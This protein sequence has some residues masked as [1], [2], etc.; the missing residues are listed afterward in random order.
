[1]NLNELTAFLAAGVTGAINAPACE[2]LSTLEMIMAQVARDLGINEVYT[3]DIAN[4]FKQLCY[5]PGL[6]VDLQDAPPELK[7][8]TVHDALVTI[9]SYSGRGLFVLIDIHPLLAKD[10]VL[11]RLLK[12]TAH[13]LKCQPLDQ[14]P[15]R[16]ILLGQD[17]LLPQEFDGIITQIKRSLPSKTEIIAELKMQA[18][19]LADADDTLRY[20]TTDSDWD[21]IARSAC[22]LTIQEIVNAMRAGVYESGAIDSQTAQRLHQYKVS[23]LDRLGV[24]VAAPADSP[25]GGF[26]NVKRF[27]AARAQLLHLGKDEAPP[28]KGILVVGHAGTGKSLLAKAV[29]QMLGL[30]VFQLQMDS[31]LGSLVGESEQKTRHILEIIS[32]AAPIVLWIDEI[33]KAFAGVQDGAGDSGVG[34]RVFG[35][36][37]TWL[38]ENSAPVFVVATA[39]SVESLPPELLRQG[40]LDR[41]FKVLLPTQ[42][43]RQEIAQIHLQKWAKA[44]DS[45]SLTQMAIQIAAQTERYSGAEIATAIQSAAIDAHCAGRPGALKMEDILNFLDSSKPLA[46]QQQAQFAAREAGWSL[47]TP[48]SEHSSAQSSLS[49]GRGSTPIRRARPLA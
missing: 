32:A 30:P 43:E 20:P 3:W 10:P 17:L 24:Q 35:M 18:E 12:V 36:L 19:I 41:I 48:V 42:T 38:Q 4:G 7:K 5:T 39:N 25:I 34:R 6:G 23:K 26:E 45:D 44:T 49:M 46:E 11:V 13:V 15:K 47:F 33:E 1:M 31:M 8:G 2:E 27:V 14:R 22:G 37:L 29:G 9:R 40:R 28:V 16:L 21:L